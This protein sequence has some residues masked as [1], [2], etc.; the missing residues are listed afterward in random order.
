MNIRMSRCPCR[1]PSEEEEE[2]NKYS[3]DEQ[4]RQQIGRHPFFS[5]PLKHV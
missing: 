2:T 5:P 3:N 4:R 1:N